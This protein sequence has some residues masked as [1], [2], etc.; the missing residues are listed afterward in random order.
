MRKSAGLLIGLVG[1]LLL[2]AAPAAAQQE[3]IVAIQVHG[4]TLTSDADLIRASGLVERASFS[5]ALLPDAEA[6]LRSFKR[7]DRVEVLKRYASISDL[8]QILI[9]IRVDEGPVRLVPPGVPGQAPSVA[10]RRRLSVMFVPILGAEDGYGV[11]YGVHFAITGH[12][13]TTQRVIVPVSW[14]GDKRAA[15]E[16]QK[17]F[18]RRFAPQVRTGMLVQRRNHP[19]FDADAARKRVWGRAEWPLGKRI[20]AGSELAWQRSTLLGEDRKSRS[21]G[22]DVIVDTRVDPLV[23]H[24]A[25]YVRAAVDRLQFTD[26]SALK[27]EID[28]NGYIGIYRGTVL[29]LRALREGISRPAPAYFKSVL[30]GSRNLRG[31]RAGDSIGDTLVA[32]SAELRVPL[33]S[34]LHVARFGTSI[35]M[36]VGTAYDK[37]QRVRDQRLKRGIGAGVWATAP[38]FHISAMVAHGMGATTRAHIGAG[39]TF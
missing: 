18:S 23:P 14:G 24:N 11:T 26:R 5:D 33:T 4:N 7:F 34:P 12:R 38:L 39:F 10:R 6:R 28:A 19:F 27:T 21:I 22:A 2:A 8:T 25:I 17:E 36:D 29:A 35:F 16:L 37:G 20:R 15:V 31:F 30:G 1:V 13:N 32:G 9:V 3:V